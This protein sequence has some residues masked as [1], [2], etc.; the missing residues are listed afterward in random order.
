MQRVSNFVLHFLSCLE[1][2]EKME[3]HFIIF[4]RTS[5]V[6]AGLPSCSHSVVCWKESPVG[7]YSSLLSF[8][9]HFYHMVSWDLTLFWGR[10]VVVVVVLVEVVSRTCV[11]AK[12]SVTG[13]FNL[14][15][16]GKGSVPLFSMENTGTAPALPAEECSCWGSAPQTPPAWAWST[17]WKATGRWN[18]SFRLC[19]RAG[20]PGKKWH[21]LRH[22]LL[23]VLN[24]WYSCKMLCCEYNPPPSP[25]YS[26]VV[27]IL[28]TSCRRRAPKCRDPKPFHLWF[29]CQ[30]IVAYNLHVLI[31]MFKVL[32][33][34]SAL[35]TT[36]KSF[37]NVI[38]NLNSSNWQHNSKAATW[39]CL[40]NK[41]EKIKKWINKG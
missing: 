22:H 40:K 13:V 4:T 12:S 32:W 11:E 7:I 35:T 21:P 2:G 10:G 24:L 19:S 23:K 17:V 3:A 31:W 20:A 5:S 1:S 30:N 9:S 41:G 14:V 26:A 27:R 18:R 15:V 16:Q 39:F 33:A 8:S 28:L 36:L 38:L 34:N 37:R 25:R 29:H 6:C